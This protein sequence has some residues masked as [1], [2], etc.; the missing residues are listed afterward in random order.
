MGFYPGRAQAARAWAGCPCYLQETK[1]RKVSIFIAVLAAVLL[2]CATA[3][4]RRPDIE[5]VAAENKKKI[6]AI[7]GLKFKNTIKF[8]WLS[9][10]GIRKFMLSLMDEDKLEAEELTFK[11]FGFLPAKFSMRKE[12]AEMMKKNVAGFYDSDSKQLVLKKGLTRSFVKKIL[13]HEMNHALQDQH[14]DIGKGLDRNPPD[15]DAEWA[16]R[17]V[18][19]GDARTVENGGPDWLKKGA[20]NAAGSGRKYRHLPRVL[21]EFFQFPYRAGSKWMMEAF[22]KDRGG[23]DAVNK[24]MSRGPDEIASTEQ[25]IHPEKYFEK[26]DAPVKIKLPNLDNSLDGF[27]LLE[28]N[29]LGELHL[30]LL[31]SEQFNDAEARKLAAGW[32]GD[33][34]RSYV[35]KKDGKPEHV[36]SAW[37]TTWDTEKDAKEFFDGYNKFLTK[38]RK[39]VKSTSKKEN[40]AELTDG[41]YII[42]VEQKGCDVVILDGM[43]VSRKKVLLDKMWAETDKK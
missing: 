13:A 19:E 15:R 41:K 1:M 21:R 30:Y 16:Y 31:F 24:A 14:F 32:D 40:V 43:P 4:A 42:H 25:I 38:H 23:F 36:L 12:I 11:K 35:L 2:S 34:Y 37:Y 28:E 5:A 22:K 9:A 20:P 26:R 10:A 18:L 3:D 6:E 29:N 33:Q 8:K 27:E 7:R 39:N 17:A